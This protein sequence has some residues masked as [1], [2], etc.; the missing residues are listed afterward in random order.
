VLRGG[1]GE[2]LVQVDNLF[3]F[4]VEEVNLKAGEPDA[5]QRYNH[6]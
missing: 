3:V 6:D 2:H 5:E 4:V 1:I